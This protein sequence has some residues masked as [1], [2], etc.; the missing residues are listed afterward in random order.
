MKYYI[1]EN[2]KSKILTSPD[3]HYLFNKETGF[4]AVWGAKTEDDPEWCPFGPLIADIEITTSCKGPGGKLCS[5]CYKSNNP[6]GEYM[7]LD[8]FKKVF[9]KLPDTLQQI[10]FGVDAQCE[11]NPDVLEI[12]AHCRDNGV[13]PNVTVADITDTTAECL[14]E[15]CGAVAVSRYKDKNYCYD[16]VKKLTDRGMDQ[17][18]IHMMISEETYTQ[19]L[20][21]IV[22]IACK[23]PRLRGLNAIVFLSLKKK[24]RGDGFTPLSQERFKVIVDFCLKHKIG[25]GFDSC[26]AHKFLD[27]IKAHT[28]CEGLKMVTEPCESTLFSLYL[29]VNGDLYPCSFCEGIDGWE[30][31]VS[32]LDCEDFIDDIWINPRVRKFRDQLLWNDRNCP[33][34]DI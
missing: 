15:L 25:F 32:V 29:D 4:S 30:F 23:E 33:V 6:D 26:S 16:S 5:F 19:A 31:G 10:A 13:I 2:D 17:V 3:F 34:F 20:E 27:S 8:T 14:S 24:G 21:T 22:D 28:D 11:S 12:M 9:D 7:T 18:N 1:L